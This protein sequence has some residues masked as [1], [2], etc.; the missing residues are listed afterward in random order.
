MW[1]HPLA[2]STVCIC[3][4]V[5]GQV[6]IS[7]AG[8]EACFSHRKKNIE[9]MECPKT[10]SGLSET[11]EH[12]IKLTSYLSTILVGKSNLDIPKPQRVQS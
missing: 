8:R 2:V 12:L 7:N 3:I 4:L 9:C 1:G 11:L 5:L 6:L 10:K